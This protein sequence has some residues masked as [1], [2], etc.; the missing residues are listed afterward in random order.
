MSWAKN[1]RFALRLAI[2]VRH[3]RPIEV[4]TCTSLCRMCLENI[5]RMR[6][7]KWK[8]HQNYIENLDVCHTSKVIKACKNVIK[9]KMN[10]SLDKGPLYQRELLQAV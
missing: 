10:I 6:Q 2:K 7:R 9:N 4:T 8:V 3:A 5:E 1:L